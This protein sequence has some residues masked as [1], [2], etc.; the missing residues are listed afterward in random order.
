MKPKKSAKKVE[1]GKGNSGSRVPSSRAEPQLQPKASGSFARDL[2]LGILVCVAFFALVEGGLRIAGF[3]ARDFSE[4][5]FVGFSGIQSLYTVKDGVASTAPS[6]LRYFNEASFKVQKPPGTVR[7]F[8]FGGSTTYGHP[9]DGRTAFARWL[10]DLLKAARPE[11]D[12]EVINAGG[13]SYASYRIVPLIKET[14]RYQPDL[15]IIY[16]GEN[17]FLERRTYAGLVEQNRSFMLIRAWLEE[18]NTYRTLRAIL[19]PLLPSSRKVTS[20]DSMKKDGATS[21]KGVEKSVLKGEVS[22]ILDRSAGLDLYHRDEEFERGVVQHF[23][24]NLKAMIS[25]CKKAG[26]PVIIVQPA[27]NLKD[28]SPFKSEHDPNLTA[29]EKANIKALLSRVRGL[30]DDGRFGEALDLAQE[31][32]RKDPMFAESHYWEGRALLGLGRNPEAKR[33]FVEAKDLDVCPL[34]CISAVESQITAI[35]KEENVP[36]IPFRESLERKA[37]ESGDKSGIPGNEIF[38]DHLHPTIENHQFL[39]EMILEK[40]Q[41]DGLV[42]LS[43]SLSPEERQDV[44][45]KG[46]ASLDPSFFGL[47]DLN[48]AKTLRWAGKKDEARFALEKAAQ[49]LPENVEI[50]KM[51]GSYLLEDGNYEK[52]IEESK[53]AVVLSGKDP[54]LVFA[55]AVAYY[56]SGRKEEA[57]A[58]Y[59]N[60]TEQEKPLPEALANLAMIYLE[61]GKLQKALELLENG[62]KATPQSPMLFSPYGLA[63][64]MSGRISDAISWMSRAVKAEPGNPAH[65]Y[66]LAGMYALSG[67]KSEALRQLD[68]AVQKGYADGDKLA[69]D[70][71]FGSIRD[72]PEFSK[73]LDKIR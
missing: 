2:A 6:K 53:A 35:A 50:H 67:N 70:P 59:K 58:T 27:S 69:R 72:V 55:L 44:F 36:L 41:A 43:R 34:R 21:E 56:R 37:A 40:I 30:L 45:K 1:S 23:V 24:Y 39:A 49:R 28:F 26:V 33:C 42:H 15:M 65:L 38:L 17:E 62:L 10:Q 48:L 12:F 73:I 68:G 13:I 60:L 57:V 51:L 4:D 7:M 20:A 47:R 25:L 18:L 19:Q 61:D 32:T 71:V 9:F 11:L 8:C 46:L 64:A 66:N 52:A 31:A 14:L 5:P 16:T 63:L 22:A 54:E 29:A 3:P